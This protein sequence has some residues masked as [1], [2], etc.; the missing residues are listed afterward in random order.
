MTVVISGSGLSLDDVVRV[1]R[2]GERVALADNAR[3]HMTRA[4]AVVEEVLARGDEVYGL[5][6]GVGTLKRVRVAERDESWFN[7]RLLDN[8]HVGLGPLAPPDVVRAAMLRLAA[9]FAGGHSGV[10]PELG[11]RLVDLLNSG[12][13][14]EIRLYGSLGQS[15]LS[16]NADLAATLFDGF[17]PAPGEALAVLNNNAFATGWAALAMA[18]A[19]TLLDASEAVGALA[20]EGFAANLT[21][22]HPAVAA[23]RPYPGLAAAITRLRALL[24]GSYLWGAGMARNLQD[25]LTFRNLAQQQGAARDAL[26]H[27]LAQL[28]VELNAAQ[29]NPLVLVGDG[30]IISAAEYEILPLAAALD[31]ARIALA[32]LLTSA[33]EHTLK[34]L[35][36]PWSGLPTGLVP[37]EGTPESGLAHFAIAAEAITAEARLLAQPVSFELVSTSGAEG[38][39]DRMTMAPLAARR[40]TEL[41]GLGQQVLTI[42]L[43]VAAQAAELRGRR[44]LGRGTGRLLALVRE[45]VPY[46]KAGDSLP[47]DLEPLRALIASGELSRL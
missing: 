8:H 16:A 38:I 11:E 42:E 36:T 6:T 5:T 29:N 40:V 7:R 39:E 27:T 1:A 3:R 4:R 15:D 45:R 26:D 13:R 22:L 32:P 17:D 2:G 34:L 23:A 14:P 20:L 47:G 35:D 24:D 19:L 18:D 31:Y 10:R 46:M 12:A 21:A 41:V 33:T 43:L 28:S 37:E 25:P 44:P 30:Q 9:G